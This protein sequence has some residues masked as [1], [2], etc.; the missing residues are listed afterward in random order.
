[1]V[2]IQSVTVD[3]GLQG[4]FAAHG[5]PR[6]V[7]DVVD[8]KIGHSGAAAFTALQP[9]GHNAREPFDHPVGCGDFGDFNRNTM[10]RFA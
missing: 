4:R 6:P 9:I 8:R 3:H 5:R 10:S 2:P 7:G 1:M